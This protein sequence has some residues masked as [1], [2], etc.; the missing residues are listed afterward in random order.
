MGNIHN[1]EWLK[2][3]LHNSIL[4]R[5]FCKMN[6]AISSIFFYNLKRGLC[7]VIAFE[8]QWRERAGLMGV[9]KCNIDVEHS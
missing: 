1:S 6:G 2:T 5:E 8:M 7:S 9:D 4:W 3:F